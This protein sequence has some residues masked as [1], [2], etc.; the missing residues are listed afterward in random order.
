MKQNPSTQML[1]ANIRI[2]VVQIK[3][4]TQPRKNYM[5][6]INWLVKTKNETA[7]EEQLKV[8]QNNSVIWTNFQSN[9]IPGQDT[10]SNEA[11]E[12]LP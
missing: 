3:T 7:G 6:T 8:I 11:L 4:Q 2:H 1:T 5:T 12:Q 10:K 9:S